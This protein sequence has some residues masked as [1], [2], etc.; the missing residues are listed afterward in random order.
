MAETNGVPKNG[1]GSGVDVLQQRLNDPEVAAGIARLLERL[2]SIN[3][4]AE[5]IE[6][7]VSRGDVIIGS[8]TDTINDLK[9][10]D[11]GAHINALVQQAPQLIETGSQFANVSKNVN[12]AELDKSQLLERL[13]DPT[14]LQT[15][16]QLLDQL[17]LIAFLLQTLE[18]FLQRGD[19]IVEN[20]AAMTSDLK[21]SESNIS[22]DQ[23]TDSLKSLPKLKELGDQLSESELIGDKMDKIINAGVGMVD[24]G[25][26]DEKVV[27]TLGDLGKKMVDT[28]Q[29][30]KSQPTQPV[31]GLWRMLKASRDPDVQ[32]S[33]GFLIA[34]A[35]AFSKHIR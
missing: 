24:A 5:A 30:I 20:I 25:M 14:T 26:L 10:A 16:N 31:G 8:V 15:L 23:I 3:F 17:P 34:Y 4:V 21:R 11:A 12:F 32:Q 9:K 28:F 18:G 1:S 19:T 6:S 7:A 2:D 22:L 33:F 29:E 13:T 27:G 35:K